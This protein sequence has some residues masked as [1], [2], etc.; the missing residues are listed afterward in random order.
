MIDLKKLTT[1][2]RHPDTLLLDTMSPLEII[3]I[4][5]QEDAKV[6]QAIKEELPKIAQVIE[7]CTHALKVKGRIIYLGAGT[8]GRLGLLDA[9]ECPPTFGV[10]H[11]TVVGLL[12][13]GVDAF[14]KAIEGAE[15]SHTLAQEEMKAIQVNANDVIIG[16]A[17]SGRTPYVIH[18]LKYAKT[19]GCKTVSMSNNKDSEM[20]Q[21]ADLAIEVVT[22]P[23][24]L[25]GSTR[26]KAG[27]SQKLV[28]NMISTASM[29]GVGKVYENLM[30]DVMQTNQKLITRAE[31]I[32]MSAT[33]CDR[34]SAKTTLQQ[35]HG[36][37]KVAITMILMQC[38]EPQ[39]LKM[40]EQAQGHIRHCVKQ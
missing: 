6:I 34:E 12:A 33:Q 27:T 16:I 8:S 38:D 28:L 15:D 5:N 17:A 21:V 13:G 37:V 30:V 10:D 18:G 24:V 32:V 4:M 14:V 3:T 22:G 29:I 23:E 9:A 35:A 25:T 2:Q 20:A 7:W 26:L 1:E 39:A 31:N 40:L 36:S 19:L 11:N